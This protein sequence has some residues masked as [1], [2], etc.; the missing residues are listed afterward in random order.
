MAHGPSKVGERSREA[1]EVVGPSHNGFLVR[2]H[3]QEPGTV[4]Q[5]VV[6]QTIREPYWNKDIGVHRLSSGE[7]VYVATSYGSKLDAAI[8]QRLTDFWEEYGA[9]AAQEGA[10][11]IGHLSVLEGTL[12]LHPKFAYRYYID[13]LANG[14]TC[15][16][17]GVDTKLKDIQPGTRIRVRGT[18]HSH[19]FEESAYGQANA[20]LIV[21]DYIYMDV[22]HLNVLPADEKN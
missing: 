12:K 10:G 2:I 19:H 1:H 14:Q 20:A 11:A 4:N 18:M 13:G 5:A 8:Q 16:L 22:R 6:P 15:G 9:K 7:Q 3:L 21:A 17:K